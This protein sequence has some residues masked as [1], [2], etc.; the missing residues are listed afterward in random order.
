[1]S[2]KIEP[3]S[4]EV[5]EKEYLS[6][7]GSVKSLSPKWGVSDTTYKKWLKNYDI[8][9]KTASQITIE[10]HLLKS[11]DRVLPSREEFIEAYERMTLYEIFKHFNISQQVTDDLLETYGISKESLGQRVSRGYERAFQDRLIPSDVI[12]EAL[13]VGN[14]QVAANNLGISRTFLRKM[15]GY[16]DIVPPR[17]FRSQAEIEIYEYVISLTSINDWVINDRSI[18]SP[19]ELDLVSPTHKIAIEYCGLYW[20][21]ELLGKRDKTYHR[22]KYELCKDNGYRLITVFESDDID[23]VKVLLRSLLNKRERIYARGCIVKEIDGH[24]AKEFND[25]YHLSS[26]GYGSVWYGL[27]NGKDLVM[28]G[29]FIKSRF[30][31]K[32]EWECSRITTGEVSVIGGV[33]KIF[34]TFIRNRDPES[35]ITYA[36]L[37]FGDGSCY[38]FSGLERIKDSYP[39]Y[40]YFKRGTISLQSRIAFQKHKLN[41][42]LETFDPDLTEWDNMKNNKYDR[43]WDCGNAVWVWTKEKA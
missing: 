24:M 6:Q 21:S 2:L 32:Y 5:L 31:K 43:I 39:N 18:I 9:L 11:K 22:K 37:R 35:L 23:K 16:H 26:H 19:F 40:W 10:Q 3:P 41:D 38:R 7:G 33:S 17:S 15:M 8:P 14:V 29:G 20:H 28:T 12:I 4:K 25:K 30:N 42:K 13:K 1:M 36:D 34:K 27:F